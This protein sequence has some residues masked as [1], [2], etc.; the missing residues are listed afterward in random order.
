MD[1]NQQSSYAKCHPLRR[2]R[3]ALGLR[4]FEVKRMLT[5]ILNKELNVEEESRFETGFVGIVG[6]SS[7]LREVLDLVEMVAAS[8][9]TAL[10]L[11]E[12]GT[13]KELIARAIHDRSRRKDRTFVRSIAP[14]FP[15]VCSKVNFLAMNAAPSPARL[16][17]R[18]AGSS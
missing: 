10:L 12:T 5:T 14:P 18:L 4:K 2:N 13:G 15:A 6:Q 9:S 3:G 11:G 8:D 7:A 1:T 16:R 17:R